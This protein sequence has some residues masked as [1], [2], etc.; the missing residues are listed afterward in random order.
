MAE[1]IFSLEGRFSAYPIVN[2][3][4]KCDMECKIETEVCYLGENKKVGRVILFSAKVGGGG[5]CRFFYSKK[6]CAILID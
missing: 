6:N 3:Y 2:I 1:R 4:V 5:C